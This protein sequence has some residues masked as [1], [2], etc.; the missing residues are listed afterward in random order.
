M[1]H[2]LRLH[3]AYLEQPF[4]TCWKCKTK[5]SARTLLLGL[6]AGEYDEILQRLDGC[7]TSKTKP[8]P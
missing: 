8:S 7:A 4:H 5:F 3:Q 2:R 6:R 1:I